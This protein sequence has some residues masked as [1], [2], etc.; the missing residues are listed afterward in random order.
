MRFLLGTSTSSCAPRA[1]AGSRRHASSAS[2]SPRFAR[3]RVFVWQP[4][5]SLAARDR[6]LG[7]PSRAGGAAQLAWID[8]ACDLVSS[9]AADALVTGPVSKD[10]IATSGARGARR[11]LGHTE[12][13][14]RR[15]H[16]REVGDGVR[17]R[18]AHDGARH[19]AH[20][21]RRS[22]ARDH[23]RV[24]ARA[25]YLA[26]E[27]PRE[28]TTSEAKRAHRGGGAQPARGRGGPHRKR[29]GAH[30]GG[31]F[32]RARAS[33]PRSRAEDRRAGAGGDGVSTRRAPATTTASSRC[34]TIKRRSR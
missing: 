14:Q 23:R 5:Q 29:R 9:G 20:P 34:I 24:V 4:T 31:N 16:A 19:D 15:L 6:E 25:T 22:A 8:A 32:V 26:R 17:D 13:L 7:H 28:S 12:H 21:A 27:F 30:R 18:R 11:F 2:R 3:G 1:V 33:R 10:A